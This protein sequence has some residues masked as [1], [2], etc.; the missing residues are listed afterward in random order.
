MARAKGKAYGRE[1]DLRAGLDELEAPPPPESPREP[2]GAAHP[3]APLPGMPT[4]MQTGGQASVPGL[5]GWLTPARASE[6]CW[7]RA[8][9]AAPKPEGP[10]ERV[11]NVSARVFAGAAEESVAQQGSTAAGGNVSGGSSPGDEATSS[12]ALAHQLGGALRMPAVQQAG[13]FG[14]GS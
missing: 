9:L 14:K 11:R 4:P 2:G 1:E 10:T 6:P 13:V 8:Q 7:Q 3:L 5:A 12:A